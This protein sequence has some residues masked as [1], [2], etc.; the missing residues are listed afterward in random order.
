MNSPLF[1]LAPP[2]SYSAVI[3]A[4]LGQHPEMYDLPEVNLFVADDYREL[5]RWFERMPRLGHGLLRAIAELGAGDQIPRNVN[6]AKQWLERHERDGTAMFFRDLIEWAQPLRLVDKSTLYVRPGRALERVKEAFPDACYLHVVRHPVPTCQG[7]YRAREELLEQVEGRQVPDFDPDRSWLAPHLRIME[8]LECVPP[9]R[10]LRVLAEDL[11]SMPDDCLAKIA[12]WLGIR[13]N[14]D[15]FP[16]MKHPE[17]SVFAC[18]GPANARYGNEATFLENPRWPSK[19]PKRASLTDQVPW[20]T[21]AS[22]SNELVDLAS[23]FRY[24]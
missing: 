3:C 17:R 16:M 10:Q 4:M 5:S 14:I 12:T 2:S 7:I 24:Q 20:Q 23:R 15:T 9:D 19:E 6:A 18:F 22:F 21:N 8:F 13:S 11:L 1:I